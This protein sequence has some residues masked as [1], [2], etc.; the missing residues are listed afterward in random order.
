MRE[1]D[2]WAKVLM[3]LGPGEQRFA[4]P[5]AWDELERRFGSELPEDY[6]EFI[7]AYAPIQLNMHLYFHHPATSSWNL[8]T[9]IGDTAEA[10]KRIDWSETICPDFPEGNPV[11]GVPGGL[12]P[13]A[14]SD[15][16]EDVF[17]I[18]KEAA[19]WRVCVYVGSDDEFYSYAMGFS[20][21]LY[22]YLI[23]EDMTGPNSASFYPGPV[24]MEYLPMRDG[25]VTTPFQGPDRGM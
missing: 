23:G 24:E 6:R 18:N 14:G 13:V 22:R 2:Y 12:I 10:Y 25:E 17:L 19:D 1:R 20:E 8:G 9:W 16:G 21:W 11:F 7:D 5:A 3:M 15:K 4:N